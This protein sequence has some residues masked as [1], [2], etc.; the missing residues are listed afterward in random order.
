MEN[1][2][3]YPAPLELQAEN[4]F[5]SLK[6]YNVF[7]FGIYPLSEHVQCTRRDNTSWIN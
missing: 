3:R 1:I 2:E 7:K 6:G 4:N 5:Y